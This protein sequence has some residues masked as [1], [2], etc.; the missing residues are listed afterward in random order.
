MSSKNIL[1]VI[2]CH[3]GYIRSNDGKLAPENDLLF[4]S[5]SQVYLPLLDMLCRFKDEGL[6]CRLSLVLSP[7][8]CSLLSDHIVQTSYIDWLDKRIAFGQ[9]EVERFSNDPKKLKNASDNLAFLQKNKSD[10]TEKYNKNILRQ[11]VKLERAGYLELVSTAGTYAFLPHYEDLQEILNA[12]IEV[13]LFAHRNHFGN[14]SEGFFLPYLGYTPGIERNLRAYGVNYAFVD[15]RSVLFSKEIP[16]SGIFAPLRTSNSLAVFAADPEV[17]DDILN[18]SKN[19]VYLN[20]NADAGF[21][22]NPDELSDLIEKDSPRV[23]STY[24][25]CANCPDSDY[26]KDA[27]LL[28]AKEDAKAFVDKENSKLSEVAG[29]VE[30]PLL[31]CCLEAD[32]LGRDWA[33][34]MVWLEE[35]I[36]INKESLFKTG[37]EMLDNQ[38]ALK[39]VDLYPASSC[40][41]GYGE[42]LLDSSNSWMIPYI[43]KM[44]LRMVD[45]AGRF[46]DDTGLK[47]RLLNLGAKELMLVQSGEWP[48]MIHDGQFSDIVSARFI[49]SVKAFT[50]VFDSLG[51]NT[52]STEWLTRIDS[53]DVLFPWMNFRIFAEKK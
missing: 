20:V 26:D 49:K 44:C 24:R 50:T 30:N 10:F 28:Q 22:R 18:F 38:F 4:S 5:I 17:S 45:L 8:L 16:Q 11:F 48:K 47:V 29:S 9:K 52:V 27:A 15:A 23:L 13:G 32:M 21:D 33:E 31:V 35:V 1:L 37:A 51:S 39:K 36:R 53:E 12:Q 7:V 25:Y 19:S 42:D 40:G 14:A 34:G 6:K 3:Q 43:R 2:N 46:P 41:S